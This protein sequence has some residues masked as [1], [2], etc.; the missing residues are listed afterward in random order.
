MRTAPLASP[1]D[2]GTKPNP[3]TNG[4]GLPPGPAAVLAALHLSDPR[5][6][7]LAHLT[8][9][10][11]RDALAFS[12]RWQLT[13]PLRRAARAAMPPW[14]RQRTDEN[15]AHNLERNA[16]L[17]GLYR[18]LAAQLAAAGIEFLALKGL[19]HCPDFGSWPEDRSQCDIDFYVPRGNVLR[20][21][22]AIL[23]LGYETM[24]HLEAFPTDH[25][26]PLIRKTGWQWRGDYFDPEVPLGIELHFQFWNDRV[27]RLP[28]PDA[29]EFWN[30]RTVRKIAGSGMA[31]L[32]P[33]DLLAYASLHLLR[34]LLRGDARPFHVY[35]VA[36]FLDLRA[37]DA[38]FWRQ[39]GTLHS[40]ELR[41]LEAVVFRLA[42]AWFGCNLHP[43]AEQEIERLPG[44]RGHG[45]RNSHCPRRAACSMRG[46]TKS[47]C[48]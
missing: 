12:D 1:A 31:A 19:A 11:W 2:C 45:S 9:R 44:R 14:V 32:C 27:E 40:P 18:R 26:P 33:P 34:H 4:P 28:V 38:V 35:E 24:D 48:T 39:W 47:G 5:L 29:V 8:D 3:W 46:R 42:A 6:E 17:E 10:Q 36:R 7:P 13:L 21:R 37:G 41:R 16:R 30:R 15:A 25:L 20:A 43:A 23:A 22:D